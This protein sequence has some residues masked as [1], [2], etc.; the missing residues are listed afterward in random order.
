MAGLGA[1]IGPWFTFWAF[2]SSTL[3]GSLLALLMM[4]YSG[5][6]YE[7][8]A[9]TQ[10]IGREVLTVRNPVALAERAAL[11]KPTMLLLPYAI[12]IALGSIA[13]FAWTGALG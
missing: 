1:W 11:R 10:I 13:Y 7:H 6:L 9:L 2:V 12:P 4:F 5:E 3:T 8:L